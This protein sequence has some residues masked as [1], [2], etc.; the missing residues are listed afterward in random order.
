MR[1]SPTDLHWPHADSSHFFDVRPHR[2]HVQL[3]GAGPD[4]LFLHGTGASTHAWADVLTRLSRDFRV[5][6]V[7]LPGH[8]FTRL[9]SRHRSRPNTMA[10]DLWA[11]AMAQGWSPS[12]IVGHS[13]GAALA[14]TMAGIPRSGQS[15]P[16]VV[17]INGALDGFDG[18]AGWLFPIAARAMATLPGVPSALAQL[19]R[20]R[21]RVEKLLKQTG[22][23]LKPD[24]ITRYANLF[25]DRDH[26]EGTLQMM[27][28]W[29]TSHL[30]HLLKSW[31]GR[32]DLLAGDR[33]RTVPPDVSRRAAQSA[34]NGHF[35]QLEN[36][37]HLA[38]EEDPDQVASLLHDILR[39]DTRR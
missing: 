16:H 10:A 20:D 31:T 9:G 22:S 34:R 12:A 35:V 33:D 15:V 17:G 30:P 24:A 39:G 28:Q 7:D 4:I 3:L 36:L 14:L 29:S 37:G 8:G 5:I 11:L 21:S 1:G 19:G 25:S 2:W 13:A 32:L 26:L 23:T 38:A 27:S 18:A 6:A